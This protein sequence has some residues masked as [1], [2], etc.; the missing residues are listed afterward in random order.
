MDTLQSMWVFRHVVESGSFTKAAELMNI[1]TAM[2][3]K[4]VRHLEH[5]IQS[6]LLNRTSRRISLT[7][8]GE[9]YYHRCVLALDTLENAGKAAQEDTL[10]PQGLFKI[11]AP[12]WCATPYFARL[13]AQYRHRYPQVVLLVHLDSR[14]TDLVAEGI[15]LALRVTSNPEPNLIVKPLTYVNFYW[16]ASPR[17]LQQY[18]TPRTLAELQ[19]HHGLAPTYVHIDVPME[20]VASSNN[21]LMLQQFALNDMG[22]AYLP[23]WIIQDDIAA[24]RLEI[25]LPNQAS[26][27]HTLYAAYMDR[28]F[29][30]AKVRSFIDFLAEIFHGDAAEGLPEKESNTSI[31]KNIINPYTY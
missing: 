22:I 12:A 17:Y 2:A 8:T 20:A 23:E 1:S 5:Y 15:D 16:V 6:K 4:H 19:K 25:L 10:K 30:G 28:E 3:S 18:G 26:S 27:G 24:G 13:L 31:I 29:L 21:A 9:Q 11:T 14:H 7:E